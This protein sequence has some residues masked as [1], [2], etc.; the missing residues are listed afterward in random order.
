LR[1]TV[2]VACGA[3]PEIVKENTPSEN[4]NPAGGA[5]VILDNGEA[6]RL[7]NPPASAAKQA[8]PP[9]ETVTHSLEVE[10][11]AVEVV[12]AAVVVMMT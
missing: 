2:T 3:R 8:D 10:L 5:V 7:V 6:V 12:E 11:E 9:A 4:V 1:V